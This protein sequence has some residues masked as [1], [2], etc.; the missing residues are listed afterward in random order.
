V[1]YIVNGKFAFRGLGSHDDKYVSIK[2]LKPYQY[3]VVIKDAGFTSL[4]L[5]IA[6]PPKSQAPAQSGGGGAGKLLLAMVIAL[7]AGVAVY[8]G[9]K[10]L[11]RAS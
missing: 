5:P 10:R 6:Q 7:V 4:D 11:V 1:N 2:M 3:R 9:S 8:F